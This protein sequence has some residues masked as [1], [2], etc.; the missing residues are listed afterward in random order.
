VSRIGKAWM[1]AT[2]MAAIG[3]SDAHLPDWRFVV[4]GFLVG[5]ATWGLPDRKKGKS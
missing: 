3:I 1:A 2:L 5:A 4:S